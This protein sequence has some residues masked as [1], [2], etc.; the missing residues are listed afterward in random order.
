MDEK[1]KFIIDKYY[2]PEFGLIND[3]RKFYNKLK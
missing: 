3:P 1:E 2:L